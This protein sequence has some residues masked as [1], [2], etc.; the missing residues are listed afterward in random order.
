MTKQHH[1]ID[2]EKAGVMHGDILKVKTRYSGQTD[3]Y[4]LYNV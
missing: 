4:I 2:F 1:L 3:K